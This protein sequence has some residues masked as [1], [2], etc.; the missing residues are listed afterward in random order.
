MTESQKILKKLI[1]EDQ[2]FLKK[3]QMFEINVLNIKRTNQALV[4][5]LFR[6]LYAIC[7]LEGL[8]ASFQEE[9][10]SSQEKVKRL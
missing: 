3:L 2:R 4:P 8:Q 1:A 7:D 6:E 5:F 10:I 9:N